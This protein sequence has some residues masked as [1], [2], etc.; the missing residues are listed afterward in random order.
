MLRLNHSGAA[1]DQSVGSRRII[2]EHEQMVT[3]IATG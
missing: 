1:G 3:A 2:K